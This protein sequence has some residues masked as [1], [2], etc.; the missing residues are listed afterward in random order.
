MLDAF[1]LFGLSLLL[2]LPLLLL[3]KDERKRAAPVD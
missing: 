3:M 2:V 1:K